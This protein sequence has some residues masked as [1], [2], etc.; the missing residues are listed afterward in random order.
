MSGPRFGTAGNSDAFYAE[1]HKHTFE[2]P[3][4]LAAQGLDAFEYSFGRG[5]KL[6]QETGE[7]IAGE[8]QR[9]GIA[10]SVHA[11]YYIN[12]AN[13]QF[14]K[15]LE[16]FMQSSMGARYLGARR[17]VFHPGGK[18]TMERGEAYARVRQTLVEI[19][20]ELKQNGFSDMVYCPETM[21]KINQIGDLE[22][23]IG[24]VSMDEML[25]PT[26]DFGHMNARTLG[27]VKSGEDY[28]VILDAMEK[29]V[30]EEKYRNMHIHFSQI[31]YTKMGEKA[32]LTFEDKTWGPFF[33]PL[34]VEIKKRSL[35]PTIICE[36]KGT[37]A[38][39]AVKMKEI[40]EA[41]QL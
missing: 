40:Y 10:M 5:A 13:D 39:D 7:K 15:N 1:G 36:S 12:L 31:E 29:S 11:P 26:I 32:H 3:A 8:A 4:W 21:G 30:G 41:I 2:A 28:A 19:L 33:E 25:Y 20:R 6:R 34:A 24:L 18:G 23:I 14:E 37:Q 17:V 9:Y 35:T 27:G 38:M 22:E 16:Y